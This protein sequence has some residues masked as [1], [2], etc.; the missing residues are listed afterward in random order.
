MDVTI[1]HSGLPAGS[2][3]DITYNNGVAGGQG[4]SL[5]VAIGSSGQLV[6]LSTVTYGSTPGKGAV[7][8]RNRKDG[9]LVAIGSWNRNYLT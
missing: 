5:G 9:A 3:F 8:C 6:T 1:T 2:L 7:E 4:E